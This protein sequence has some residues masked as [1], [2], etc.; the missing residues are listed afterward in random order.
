MLHGK[1]GGPVKTRPKL[2]LAS[3]PLFCIAG[4]ARTCPRK[5]FHMP[6]TRRAMIATATLAAAAHAAAAQTQGKEMTTETGLKFTDTT[7]GTGASPKSGQ[8][9][10]MHYTGW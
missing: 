2:A 10:V 3:S 6:V 4:P 1:R 8:T 7:V 9:C 5:S